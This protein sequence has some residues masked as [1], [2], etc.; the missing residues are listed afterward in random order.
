MY[1][2]AL[3]P[4]LTYGSLGSWPVLEKLYNGTIL[5]GIKELKYMHNWSKKNNINRGVE[6]THTL[7]EVKLLYRR[8]YGRIQ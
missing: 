7:F 4:I 2:V 8:R 3:R 6:C 5:L 1:T